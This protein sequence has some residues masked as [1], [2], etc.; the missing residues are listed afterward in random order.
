MTPQAQRVRSRT[1]PPRVGQI[2]VEERFP[3]A[4][5]YVNQRYFDSPR[6]AREYRD[7]RF[8]EHAVLGYSIS[9]RLVQCGAHSITYFVV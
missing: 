5:V 6:E 4:D 3:G 7:Q 9:M 1:P 2:V 8:A